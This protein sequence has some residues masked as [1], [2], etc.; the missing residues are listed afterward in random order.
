MPINIVRNKVV[1]VVRN[2][3]TPKLK[4]HHPSSFFLAQ[5]LS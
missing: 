4:Y 5:L 1:R 3:R 2:K